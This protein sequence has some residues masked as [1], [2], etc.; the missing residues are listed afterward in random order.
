M[1]KMTLSGGSGRAT[2]QSPTRLTVTRDAM[3]A[4]IV[5]SSPYYTWMKVDGTQYHPTSKQGENARFEIP[6]ELDAEIP[7]SAETVAMSQPH[8]VDYTLHFDSSTIKST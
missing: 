1:I 3:T 4:E 7:V 2:V 5:W 6:V 8:I